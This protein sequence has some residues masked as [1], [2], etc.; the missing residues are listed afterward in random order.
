MIS[1]MVQRMKTHFQK[2]ALSCE[3]SCHKTPEQSVN[4]A[5]TSHSTLL[6]EPKR[7]SPEFDVSGPQLKKVQFY[8]ARFMVSTPAATK[9]KI[10]QTIAEFIYGCNL[11]FSEVEDPLFHAW[12]R[13]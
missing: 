1:V 3:V 13:P 9:L 5:G 10:D 8:M 7:H 4:V 11:S 2:C 12:F 6:T